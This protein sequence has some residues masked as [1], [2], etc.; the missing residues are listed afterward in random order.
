MKKSIITDGSKFP[1]QPKDIHIGKGFKHFWDA[2]DN[3]ET[4]VSAFYVVGL[5]QKL[6][7]WIPF[8]HEQI[9]QFY[10]ENGPGDGFT[11]NRLVD[12]QAVLMNP[13][14]EFGRMAEHANLCRGMNPIMASLSYTMS[15]GRPETVRKGGGWIVLGTD[16]KYYVT[17]D[18]VARC[19][20][21]SPAPGKQAVAA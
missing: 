11:F 3:S 7:G 17:D 6:G 15:H 21:S 14:E 20:K 4:E 16:K 1:I 18:F 12:Q 5:C 2:F 10:T 8:T 19:F 13:A 9:E